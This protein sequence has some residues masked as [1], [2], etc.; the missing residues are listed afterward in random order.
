MLGV[1]VGQA[2]LAGHV[3]DDAYGT[4]G[5][6]D[7][8]AQTTDIGVLFRSSQIVFDHLS[9]GIELGYDWTQF[10]D[11]TD[12]NGTGAYNPPQSPEQN[13]SDIGHNGD[14]TTL[15][16]SGGHVALV[17]GLWSNAPVHG[18]SSDQ[19]PQGN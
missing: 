13:V 10:K 4:T 8:A 3:E 19:S 6:Y 5:S 11:I 9:I 16:F 17:I 7:Q 18:G 14:Q 12:K 15:D 2:N 1:R